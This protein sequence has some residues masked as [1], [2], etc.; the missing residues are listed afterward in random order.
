[1]NQHRPNQ[2]NKKKEKTEIEI[3]RSGKLFQSIK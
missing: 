1:M 2:K 3:N